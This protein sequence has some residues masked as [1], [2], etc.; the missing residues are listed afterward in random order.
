[1]LFN[2]GGSVAWAAGCTVAT[3]G[4]GGSGSTTTGCNP[5]APGTDPLLAQFQATDPSTGRPYT[6]DFGW[7][8][9]T[10]ITRTSTG[11]RNPGLHRGRAQPEH[12]LGFHPRVDAR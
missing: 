3:G 9:H 11:L 6:G 1:M 12:E 7:I 8:S 5:S 2:G 10:W 4:D